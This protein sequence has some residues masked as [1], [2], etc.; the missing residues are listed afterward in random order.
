MAVRQPDTISRERAPRRCPCGRGPFAGCCGPLLAGERP[1]ET[2][3]AILAFLGAAPHELEEYPR[4]FD[5]DY[6][7]MR[8]E[9]RHALTE[10]FAE[11]NRRLEALLGR[12][13]G[14]T[15]P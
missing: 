12:E 1:A 7:P 9:T 11:P 8:P 4:V 5:R 6:E 3:A 15:R 14:W 13:L 2:Y 10:R